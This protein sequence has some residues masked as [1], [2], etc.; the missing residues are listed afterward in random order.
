MIDLEFSDKLEAQISKL[1]IFL[2]TWRQYSQYA[3]QEPEPQRSG[4]PSSQDEQLLDYI[5]TAFSPA[6]KQVISL[7]EI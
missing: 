1:N 2:I 4:L 3:A 6:Q 7:S 5:V